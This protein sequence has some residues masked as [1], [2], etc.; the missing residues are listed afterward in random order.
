[1]SELVLDIL[2]LGKQYRLGEF[3]RKSLRKSTGENTFWALKN[4]SFQVKR[5][6]VLGIV[7][8]N[9]AGKST[10]L[11]LLSQITTPSE[12]SI[13]AKGKM[14]SLLEV[15]TGM[16]PDLTGRENIFL[17]GAI[18]GMSK[19]EIAKKFNDIVA[20]SECQDF[21]DTP[22]KRYSSGMKVRLGFAVAVHLEP[23]IV[24][25]DEV[26]AVGDAA[27]QAKAIAKIIDLTADEQRT[28]IFVSHNMATVKSLCARCIYLKKGQ[29]VFDGAVDKAIS[30]Y[31][32]YDTLSESTKRVWA[33]DQ[34]G[35]DD[36]RLNRAE[37]R[38]NGAES[39]QPLT[40]DS[41]IEIAL[42]IEN[43]K[44]LNLDCTI[45]ICSEMGEVIAVTSTLQNTEDVQYC[46][47][48]MRFVVRIPKLIFNEKAY[49]VNVLFVRDRQHVQFRYDDILKLNIVGGARKP[50][51]WMGAI[52]SHFVP[53][54][55][56]RV[57]SQT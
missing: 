7:G 50:D 2:K 4:V 16:H 30:K 12:G 38:V 28:V 27:F 19:T 46:N 43:P 35:N 17:N 49:R 44:T 33:S 54:W 11:K 48:R 1:M 14:A 40:I 42:D 8:A 45:Q 10:L 9:G 52:Q 56:W 15:G 36:I 6:E 55:S 37:V 26:L 20:F 39:T 31:L 22:L 23:D 51:Q 57:E 21:I 24:I 41:E 5:G 53:A 25:I 13:R 29:I 18:L 3:G 34:P 47:R 32:G